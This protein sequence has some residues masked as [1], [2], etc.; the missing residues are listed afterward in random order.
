MTCKNYRAILISERVRITLLKHNNCIIIATFLIIYDGT[1]HVI[2]LEAQLNFFH[3]HCHTKVSNPNI[4][5]I[6]FISFVCFFLLFRSVSPNQFFLSNV[7]KPPLAHNEVY[8]LI[9][10]SSKNYI[11]FNLLV[12]PSFCP[13]D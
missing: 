11:L 2:H 9:M 8:N 4:S 1:F 5:M 6:C 7:I 10:I 12:F 13:H 3:V